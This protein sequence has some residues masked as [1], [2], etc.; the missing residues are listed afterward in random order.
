MS[1]M[2][3]TTT[4]FE[5]SWLSMATS[6]K[7]M[8]QYLKSR[9]LKSS[10]Q[11][12]Q[13]LLDYLQG[14]QWSL[15][16][17]WRPE[18]SCVID[19]F[20]SISRHMSM[21][22]NPPPVQQNHK[23][24]I[25]VQGLFG[26]GKTTMLLGMLN[27]GFWNRMFDMDEIC[28]CAFNVCIKEE[29]RKKIQAWGCK[30]KANVRTFDSLIYEF[31]KFYD[32]PQLKLPNYKGK[33][34]YVYNK[35]REK[36]LQTYSEFHKIKYLFVDECQDL[37]KA[38]FQ[39][40]KTFFPNACII[41]V[42]DIFQS[43]QKEPR[44][45]LLWYV[46]R[47][48][49]EQVHYF[50]MRDTPRV[51]KNIL[52]EIQDALTKS[53]PEYTSQI[54]NWE[55]SNESHNSNIIWLPF[56]TYGQLY[57]KMFEFLETHPP[58]K[59]MIL[60]FSSCITVRGSLG[61]LARVRRVI[62]QR[63]YAVNSNYKN[64]DKK[65]LFLSTANSS[66]GLERDFVFIMSTFPLEKAF[67]NFSNDLTTNLIT[68]ALSRAKQ[69]VYVCV[70]TDKGRF[71]QAF[72][73]YLTCP[74]PNTQYVS[75]TSRKPPDT[76]YQDMTKD[77]YIYLEH[78]VTE[79][80]RQTILQYETRILFKSF[81]KKT[82]TSDIIREGSV[83]PI[84]KSCLQSEEERS[85]V[86]VCIEV[87]MTSLWTNRFPETPSLKDVQSN[88]YYQHCISKII[89]LRQLYIQFKGMY[90]RSVSTSYE[91]FKTIFLYTEL[92]IA[93]HHKMFF[94]FNVT[95][96]QELFRY[97]VAFRNHVFH[98]RPKHTIPFSSQVNVKMPLL[99][100]IADGILND[101]Q[102]CIY[103][104]KASIKQDWKE[105]AF[106][107]A[108]C[109]AIMTGQAWFTIKLVN[110]FKNTQIEYVV[111]IDN[112]KKLRQTLLYDIL[113]WNASSY[114]A[115]NYQPLLAPKLSFD[116]DDCVFINLE[117]DILNDKPSEVVVMRMLSPTRFHIDF[118]GE[119]MEALETFLDT[120]IFNEYIFCG[121]KTDQQKVNRTSS[122]GNMH[123][124]FD[125]CPHLERIDYND[126]IV[127][128]ETTDKH[129][130]V[131]SIS[132]SNVVLQTMLYLSDI[133]I[134]VNSSTIVVPDISV[135][136]C[137]TD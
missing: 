24:I 97:W 20:E 63:G 131:P 25:A 10:F 125:K 40:F 122:T 75:T 132:S 124:L 68:V 43:V 91:F 82:T 13:D 136:P 101:K 35:C 2:P 113:V 12:K 121:S 98:L 110:L 6:K 93:M 129:I 9:G 99:T 49:Q 114:M 29:I 8:I 38:S 58:E 16:F 50:Y 123:H 89:T 31:C 117:W 51:P 53:Y 34:L 71:S 128:K 64:M 17:P 36:N 26:C 7:D 92:H 72:Y 28:F 55:S 59:S 19:C 52:S 33:R 87:L 83:P 69:K 126:A 102:K 76:L 74:A 94:F 42:G 30:K 90:Y 21:V 120:Y 56:Q 109:Y 108:F 96:R 61:D 62:Q 39:V 106:V 105:D 60:T 103:E 112:V 134:P 32:Y 86:G 57:E 104:I 81:V 66:K 127:Q 100:G 1:I 14:I 119:T 65:C 44:E 45:S 70:P 78:N 4:P 22:S 85:F 79:I 95:Q 48:I 80:L 115:K 67:I 18:Q 116:M 46:S 73:S 54:Q 5:G 107:Q 137:C 23:N 41:F 37:E 130:S 135:E 47:D 84:P 27:M 15:T 77:D 118:L 3:Q 11:R 111:Y 133:L 88:P